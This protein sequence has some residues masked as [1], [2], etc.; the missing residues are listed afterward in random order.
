M[1]I[2][3]VVRARVASTRLPDKTLL[4]AAGKTMLEHTLER[5]ARA[6]FVDRVVVA[7]T[8]DPADDAIAGL[9]AAAGVP[10]FRGSAD[11]VLGRVHAC[12][13]EHGMTAVAHF[14]AD[15]PLLD[16]AVCDEVLAV[17]A[18]GGW[19]YVTNNMPPTFPD[20]QEVEVTSFAALETAAREATEPRHR[21]HLLTYIWDDPGRFR[22]RN[23]EHD[24]D[25]HHVRLTLDTPEDW[26][27]VH[28]VIETLAPRD[29]AFGLDAVLALLEERP[30]LR[31]VGGDYA[32]RA[33][34]AG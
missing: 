15:N 13:A 6:S 19:D 29:P 3:A 2:D 5:V 20:G 27:V 12:A 7:T 1:S 23:V 32:W 25:L 11:D 8:D 14:G 4:R 33:R 10:C 34:P 31:H 16:P 24:P 17:F 26:R 28:E 22:I 30:E 9:C 21:E 18:A